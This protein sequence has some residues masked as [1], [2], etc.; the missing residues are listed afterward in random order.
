MRWARAWALRPRDFGVSM[1]CDGCV[2]SGLEVA[3][4][5]TPHCRRELSPES[6]M[7]RSNEAVVTWERIR[8]GEWEFY[9]G[10]V[11]KTESM[12]DY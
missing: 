9:G 1:D 3:E 11:V 12:W 10:D 4:F 2:P 7:K 8:N 6:M 5:S